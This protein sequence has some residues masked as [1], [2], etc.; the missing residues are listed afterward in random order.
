VLRATFTH[1]FAFLILLPHWVA[2]KVVDGSCAVQLMPCPQNVVL[3]EGQYRFGKQVNIYF[4]GMSDARQTATLLRLTKQLQ[5]LENFDFIAFNVQQSNDNADVIVRVKPPQNSLKEPLI[6]YLFPRL[7]DDESYQLSITQTKLIIQSISEFGAMHGL[8]TLVQLL[9]STDSNPHQSELAAQ[10]T[11]PSLVLPLLTIDDKPTFKWRGLLIDSVRHFIPIT[12][13]KRQLDGMAGAKL[14]VFHWHLNDDQGWRIESK[15]YPKL[16]QMAS[17]NLYYTQA[18]IRD[19]VDYAS[20]LGIRVVPELDV[21]GH[22]SSIAVAYPELMAE[23]KDYVMERQWGVFEPVLDVSDPK[24]YQFID[25]LV[26]EFSQLFPDNYIHIGGDEVNP[27]QW[28]NNPTTQTLMQ[29]EQLDNSEDLHHYFNLKV[30]GILVKYQRKMMGWDEIHHPD[31]P[32][33]IVIQSWRGLESMNHF[34]NSGYQGV[35]STGFYIDQPQY[36]AYHYRNHPITNVDTQSIAS[37]HRILPKVGDGNNRQGRTWKLSIPRL[38]GSAVTGTFTLFSKTNDNQKQQLNGYLKLNNNAF[39]KVS[40]LSSAAMLNSK[41]LI[42]SLDSWMGPLRF[43][44]DIALPQSTTAVS[45]SPSKNRLF[46]GNAFYPLIANELSLSVQHDISL[47]PPLKL[48]NTNNILGGEATLWSELVTQHNIDL[49]I[50]PRLFVI[51]ER[52]WSS[53]QVSNVDNMYQRLFSIDKFSEKILG[54]QHNKQQRQGISGLLD[55][56]SNQNIIALMQL[57]QLV[58][59]AHYYTRHHLKYRQGQYH[60]LAALDDFVDFLPV[61]S[62]EFIKLDKLI[63]AYQEGDETVLSSIKLRVKEWQQ[64]DIQLRRLIRT[65]SRLGNLAPLIKDVEAFNHIADKIL[66][67]CL[68]ANNLP[69]ENTTYTV[70]RQK[71]TQLQEQQNETVI[72]GILPFQRLLT[73][74]QI[75]SQ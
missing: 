52:L 24:V 35:L 8:T 70:L 41:L 71:L 36:S 3:S 25:A 55:D 1:F 74:C 23:K 5:R 59:P 29:T 4:E 2:A 44:L 6:T 58:E 11:L 22:A 18:E 50:W 16:H 65:D 12:A 67:A 51:A 47:A 54:L 19:V 49:R 73:H 27:T 62:V 34:A 39:K 48:V 20:L 57:A 75:M 30:Q 37:N 46:I 32:K 15:R 40:I 13:I 53:P 69:F 68:N 72:A 26:A 14:N 61:E 17:D 31:L 56:D 21:P 28:L 10:I 43:E 63:T 38:K 66:N 42:F 64:N 9:F 45:N 33:D 60:Q 7:G